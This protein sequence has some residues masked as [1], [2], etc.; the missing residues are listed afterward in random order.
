MS[1]LDVVHEE[2]PCATQTLIVKMNNRHHS[3]N[4][5]LL[6]SMNGSVGLREESFSFPSADECHRRWAPTFS[7]VRAV[8]FFKYR[9]C[10]K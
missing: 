3:S 5:Q 1:D 7:V 4:S 10:K 2:Q 6:T 9:V 8:L